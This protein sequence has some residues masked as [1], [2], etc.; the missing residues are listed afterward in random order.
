MTKNQILDLWLQILPSLSRNDASL[1]YDSLFTFMYK[2]LIS[3]NY[4]KL[5]NIGTISVTTRKDTAYR[6][7]KTKELKIKKQH[8]RLKFAVS[9]VIKK[10]LNAT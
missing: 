5:P 6:H 2:D 1:L 8:Q 4:V 3:L 7:P 10:A 9:S